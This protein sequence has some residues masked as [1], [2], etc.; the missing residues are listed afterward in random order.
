MALYLGILC[1]LRPVG[2]LVGL[3]V[4]QAPG[5]MATVMA[6]FLQASK[7]TP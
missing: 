1:I 3:V 2:I 4:V 6:A 5:F 7:T